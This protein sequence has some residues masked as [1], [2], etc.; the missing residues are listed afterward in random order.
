ME[1]NS[2]RARAP[3]KTRAHYPADDRLEV[4]HEPGGRLLIAAAH[5]A[6]EFVK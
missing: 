6:D 1:S 3:P 5:P 4:P 2:Q